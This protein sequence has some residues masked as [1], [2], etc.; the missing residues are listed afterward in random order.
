MQL[1][2]SLVNYSSSM[3]SKSI[4]HCTIDP[5]SLGT[6]QKNANLLLVEV[7]G[8][9]MTHTKFPA[10]PMPGALKPRFV[11]PL[12]RSTHWSRGWDFATLSLC[13]LFVLQHTLQLIL[14]DFLAYVSY[15][16]SVYVVYLQS[17]CFANM[18]MNMLLLGTLIVILLCMHHLTKQRSMPHRV[19]IL[20]VIFLYFLFIF[21]PQD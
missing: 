10:K 12:C 16:C 18:A 19:P 13:C 8:K 4:L 6:R 3:H 7:I 5:Q 11:K 14:H 17:K 15:G 21:Y 9:S 1:P 2:P 20:S